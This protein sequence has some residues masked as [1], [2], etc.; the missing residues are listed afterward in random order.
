VLAELARLGKLIMFADDNV[1][2]HRA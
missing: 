1:M 2:I